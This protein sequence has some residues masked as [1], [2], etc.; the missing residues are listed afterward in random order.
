MEYNSDTW[1]AIMEFQVIQLWKD[2]KWNEVKV[3]AYDNKLKK[4]RLTNVEKWGYVD[5][6]QE[7]FQVTPRVTCLSFPLTGEKF[8]EQGVIKHNPMDSH[9]VAMLSSE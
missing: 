4:H 5:L 9:F 1:Q 3:G 2:G 7:K 6:S 8:V